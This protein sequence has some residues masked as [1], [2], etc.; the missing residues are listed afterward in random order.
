MN[1]PGA[2]APKPLGLSIDL[3][4]YQRLNLPVY[5]AY[6]EIFGRNSRGTSLLDY[7]PIPVECFKCADMTSFVGE[8]CV[9]EF[10]SPEDAD[11]KRAVHRFCDTGLMQRS[12]IYAF[13]LMIARIMQPTTRVFSLLPSSRDDVHSQASFMVTSFVETIGGA[14]SGHFSQTEPGLDGLVTAIEK[15][16]GDKVPVH[17]MGTPEQYHLL[18]DVMGNRSVT[19]D[20]W[21]CAMIVGAALHEPKSMAELKDRL[22]QRIGINRRNIY[23]EFGMCEL[24]SQGY[25]ICGMNCTG[26]DPEEGLFIFPNWVKCLVFNPETMTPLLPGNWGRIAIFDLCSLD[27]AAF[28]LTE[29]EGELV[30]LPETLRS[31]VQGHPKYALKLGGRASEPI[32]EGCRDQWKSWAG[33]IAG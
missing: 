22:A 30:T 18:L 9:A 1:S 3:L 27:S 20:S 6:C 24:S 7:P 13:T 29:F 23:G 19:S 8:R 28:V 4:E 2:L 11:G 21:S 12:Q 15:A 14:G 26:D 5:G 33:R 32:P 10:H 25:E 31:R 16:S 17:L